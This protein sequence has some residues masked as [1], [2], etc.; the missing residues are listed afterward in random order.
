MEGD[1]R[2]QPVCHVWPGLGGAGVRVRDRS[3]FGLGFCEEKG[4]DRARLM[5]VASSA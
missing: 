2:E 4:Q 1:G 5:A 3:T